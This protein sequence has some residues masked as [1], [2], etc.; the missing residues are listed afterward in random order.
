MQ[1]II[2]SLRYWLLKIPEMFHIMTETE[3]TER[4]AQ[5]KWSKKECLGH[6]CDSALIN[7]ERFIKIQYDVS[8]YVVST[9]DQV[10]WV[11][12]QGYQKMPIEEILLLW[13]SLNKKIVVVLENLSEQ[14]L[15]RP[16]EIGQQQEVTLKWLVQD[17]LDHLEHHVKKHL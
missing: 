3:M 13:T 4:T 5:N 9:Y 2:E 10:Q 12:L 15:S 16:C 8:P 7:L 1:N 17:Y 11:E 6:L 14:A